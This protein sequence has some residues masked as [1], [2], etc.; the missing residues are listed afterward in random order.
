MS[1][2]MK[3]RLRRGGFG[4]VVRRNVGEELGGLVYDRVGEGKGGV[5]HVRLEIGV[6][7]IC[8]FSRGFR[9]AVDGDR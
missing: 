3:G 1:G 6:V 7:W 5:S 4:M 2:D 8:V 9:S